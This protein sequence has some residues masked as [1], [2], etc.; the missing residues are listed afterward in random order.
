MK[1]QSSKSS[2]FKELILML[3]E[4]LQRR[5]SVY[6]Y[7][8]ITYS[9][10]LF[11]KNPELDNTQQ[12]AD[13]ALFFLGYCYYLPLVIF[14]TIQ[15]C[16]VIQD[17]AWFILMPI[18]FFFF[19]RILLYIEEKII[20]TCVTIMTFIWSYYYSPV[21][22]LGTIMTCID[23]YVYNENVITRSLRF[24]KLNVIPFFSKK[25]KKK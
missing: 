13:F 9:T 23:I 11:F 16:I 8:V 24:Y 6:V 14:G 20:M 4:N 17:F 21:I 12:V 15:A 7:I 25:I 19:I 2:K 18:C 10:F 5:E 3:Y 1:T 22:I